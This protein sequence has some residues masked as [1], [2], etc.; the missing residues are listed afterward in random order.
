MFWNVLTD[1][2]LNICHCSSA[3]FEDNSPDEGLSW[4]IFLIHDKG[5]QRHAADNQRNERS[6]TVPGI[7]DTSPT[8]WYEEAGC[9]GDEDHQAD[10]VNAPKFLHE[11][12][13]LIV[14]CEEEDD[15]EEPNADEW[16]VDPEDPAPSHVLREATT[17]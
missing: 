7:L 8:N 11:G 4:H 13:D 14:D 16:K 2:G 9:G 12:A 15:H 6:P 1:E 5:K 10:P 17:E 3:I